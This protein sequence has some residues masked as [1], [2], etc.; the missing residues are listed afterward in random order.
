[1]RGNRGRTTIG[2]ITMF[3]LLVCVAFCVFKYFST[4]LEKKSVKKDIHDYLGSSRGGHFTGEEALAGL[5]AI[6]AKHPVTI[7][8]GPYVDVDVSKSQIH[9]Q[10]TY[11]ICTNY[12]LF[13][14]TESVSIDGTIDSYGL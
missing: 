5:N 3:V 10:V 11:S 9:Y 4:S 6:L 7:E 8:S 12:I 13:K 1:M 14:K 2:D